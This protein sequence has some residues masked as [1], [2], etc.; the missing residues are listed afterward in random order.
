MNKFYVY[1]HYIDGEESPFYIGKGCGKR[2]YQIWTKT[3]TWYQCLGNSKLSIR[4]IKDEMDEASAYALEEKL[5]KELN[6]KANVASG[7]KQHEL[8]YD[9]F[10]RHFFYDISSPSG[11]RFKIDSG[12]SGTY[13]MNKAESVAG[14]KRKNKDGSFK[15]WD[16]TLKG[17]RYKVHRIIYTLLNKDFNKSLVIDHLDGNPLNND[18]TN[19]IA[20]TRKHNNQNMR[21]NPNNKSNYSGVCLKK[22][23]RKHSVHLYWQARWFDKSVEKSK[24]FSVEK[25]GFDEAKNLALAYRIEQIKILNAN[26]EN[27]THRHIGVTNE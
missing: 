10:N 21:L 20:K 13:F 16:V 17:V 18:I 4:I 19:L 5:I 9:L 15:C 2:A 25:Y 14:S 11:L 1:G 6:P 26:G 8:D 12:W 3:E 27:F 22:F 23:K 24:S 7:Y